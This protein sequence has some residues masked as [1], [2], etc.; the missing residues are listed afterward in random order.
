M[1]EGDLE[2]EELYGLL[3]GTWPAEQSSRWHENAYWTGL[4]LRHGGDAQHQDRKIFERVGL[5]DLHV[6]AWDRLDPNNVSPEDF[7]E[8]LPGSIATAI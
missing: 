5:W 4:M 1:S 8:G 2:R 3:I 7:F 6:D